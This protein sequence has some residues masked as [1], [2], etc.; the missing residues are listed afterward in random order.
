V[1]GLSVDNQARKI[2]YATQLDAWNLDFLLNIE[3]HIT[4]GKLKFEPCLVFPSIS[5]TTKK[6]SKYLICYVDIQESNL[7]YDTWTPL[8]FYQC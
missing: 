5:Y 8:V 4:K 2:Y 1:L 3:S 7:E 6:N